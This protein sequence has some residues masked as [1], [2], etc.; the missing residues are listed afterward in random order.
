MNVKEIMPGFLAALI[1]FPA[2]T[3]ALFLYFLRNIK[4]RRRLCVLSLAIYG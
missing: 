3:R 2:M 4:T 1:A